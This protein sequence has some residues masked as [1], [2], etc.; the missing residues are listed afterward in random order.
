MYPV[1]APVTL[2]VFKPFLITLSDL[3]ENVDASD[4][5]NTVLPPNPP[6]FSEPL[7]LLPNDI[8][9]STSKYIAS[10]TIVS[11][12]TTKS[13]SPEGSTIT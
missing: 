12:L 8:D 4:E 2:T 5:P 7:T 10:L 6:I 13:S 11:A 3:V 9:L 1:P